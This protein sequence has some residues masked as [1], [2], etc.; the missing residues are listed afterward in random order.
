LTLWVVVPSGSTPPIGM[1]AMCLFALVA[2]D[3]VGVG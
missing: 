2:N 3:S 1:A